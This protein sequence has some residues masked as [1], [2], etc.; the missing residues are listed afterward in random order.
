MALNLHHSGKRFLSFLQLGRNENE[1]R[2]ELS[3]Q[4]GKK[5]KEEED[6]RVELT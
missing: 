6:E 3:E 1:K 4:S 2:G 5:E